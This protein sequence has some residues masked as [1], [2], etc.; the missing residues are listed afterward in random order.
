MRT[1]LCDFLEEYRS[2]EALRLHMP[3]HKGALDALDVTEIDGADVL[4]AP[5]GIL[6]ESQENA[7]KL[8]GSAKTL[9]SAEGSSLSVKAM[10][11]LALLW[12][13]ERGRKP[14]VLAARN[15]HRSFVS[16]AA[17]LDLD[18]RWIFSEEGLLSCRVTPEALEQ[19]LDAMETLPI[20]VYVTTPDYLGNEICVA[21]LADLCHKRGVLLLVDNA[22][23]AYL[24]FL[25]TSRHPMDLGADACCDSAHKTLSALT[26]AA[27]LHLSERAPKLFLEQA[28]RAMAIFASTSPSYL[29][30]RSL[31][32]LNQT[33]AEGYREELAAF[34]EKAERMK[35]RLAEYGY[36]LVGNEPLKLTVRAQEYGYDGTELGEILGEKGIVCEFCDREYLTLMLTPALGAEDLARLEQAMR[37]IPKKASVRTQPPVLPI[38]ER[39][40]SIR[41]GMLVAGK[42]I[43][44]AESEGKIL[45]DAALTCPPAVPILVCGERITKA[46]IACFAYYGIQRVRVVEEN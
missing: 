20:A 2:R 32:A 25:P 44:V 4:Y 41:E 14:T 3:G 29:I 22:H 24:R 34:A 45:A 31:D 6:R 35:A 15:V 5:T 16:A 13:K 23:G 39:V 9:Y 43:P 7:A 1:P 10:L 18:V 21:E 11:Y 19:A 27:Y 12:G 46:A 40:L 17:L 30:L 28:E 42:E 37:D 36:S 33:L 8:F 26:G 38:A